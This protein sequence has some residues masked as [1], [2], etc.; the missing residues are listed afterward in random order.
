MLVHEAGA[1]INTE[2]DLPGSCAISTPL[3]LRAPRCAYLFALSHIHDPVPY[4]A[5]RDGFAAESETLPQSGRDRALVSATYLLTRI[6]LGTQ[7]KSDVSTFSD[8]GESY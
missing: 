6:G 5:A 4:R 3:A 8:H 7:A 2:S 1:V